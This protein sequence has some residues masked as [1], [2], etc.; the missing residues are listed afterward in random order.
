MTNTNRTKANECYTCVHKRNVPGDC[1][2]QRV[3]PDM[4]MEGNPHG[5]RRGWFMYPFLFDPCW[6]ETE[7]K[8]YEEKQ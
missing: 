8:N 1:H 3:K 5:I 2:I 4:N 7:C 6:K